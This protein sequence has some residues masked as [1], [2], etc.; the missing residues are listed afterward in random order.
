MSIFQ[1]IF[2]AATFL[3]SVLISF[4]L[5]GKLVSNKLSLKLNFLESLFFNISLG[6]VVFTLVSYLLDWIKLSILI[7]PTLLVIAY[8]TLKKGFN[9]RKFDKKDK[10]YLFLILIITTLFSL[11]I[12]TSGQFG[13]S[14][15]FVGANYFD[16]LWHVSL[17][18]ELKHHFPPGNPG[19][20]GVPLVGY[21]FFFNYVAAKLSSI[22]NTSSL[23]LYFHFFPV[24]IAFLWALGV[25]VLLLK[26]TGSRPAAIWAVFLTIFGGSFSFILRLQGHTGSLD[27][28]FGMTQPFSSLLNP[29]FAISIVLIVAVLFSL[30]EYFKTKENAWLVPIILISGTITM[31]KVYAG[32]IV[33]GALSLMVLI[34]LLK[35][36]YLFFLAFLGSILLFFST[37]WVFHDP[38]SRLFFFPFWAP[39]KVLTDNLPW[40]GFGESQYTFYRLHVLR[41]IFRIESDAFDYFLFGSLG[42]RLIGV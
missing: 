10:P 39:H 41:G 35:K 32:I 26:W 18:N 24:L 7:L 6:I 1:P 42:T 16:G 4:Y 31:F 14:L 25:F 8:L 38:S 3:L 23:S 29:P 21:H 27:D 22:F 28:A 37:Y 30:L 34:Q 13:E 20:T 2:E 15:R 5:P 9:V 17:I 19:F 11:P 12:I 36:N 40:Y 33:L